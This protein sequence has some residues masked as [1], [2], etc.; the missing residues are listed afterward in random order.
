MSLAALSVAA[1][2]YK[3][4]DSAFGGKKEGLK[5]LPTAFACLFKPPA[6]A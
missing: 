2:Q 4:A 6:L 3:P 1:C 5:K